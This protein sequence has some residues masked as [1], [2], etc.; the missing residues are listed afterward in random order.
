MFLSYL[1]KDLFLFFT[2]KMRMK[3]KRGYCTIITYVYK[4]I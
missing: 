4:R 2:S 1:L 3:S